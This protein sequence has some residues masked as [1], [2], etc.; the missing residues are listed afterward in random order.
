[1]WGSSSMMSTDAGSAT[2]CRLRAMRFREPRRD[3]RIFARGK[4]ETEERAAAGPIFRPDPAVVRGDNRAAYRQPEANAARSATVTV[5]AV[6]PFENLFLF[7]G[8][9]PRAPIGDVHGDVLMILPHRDVDGRARGRVLHG[10]LEQVDEHLF[11]ENGIECGERDLFRDVRVDSPSTELALEP[12]Q[13][14]AD[15]FVDCLR[16][17]LHGDAPRL[18]ASELEEV[19][20]EAVQPFGF[21]GP[22]ASEFPPLA[23]F[24]AILAESGA[25]ADE[26]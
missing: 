18:E 20:D 11:Q 14:R 2:L 5:A 25:R 7:A 19:T 26:R 23:R 8:R 12:V 10:V 21:G 3:E 24:Q 1:M 15:D 17:S 4:G 22:H 13:S 6:E 16:H 9:Y